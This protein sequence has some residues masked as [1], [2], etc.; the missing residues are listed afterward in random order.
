MHTEANVNSIKELIETD[1]RIT[2]DEIV[3]ETGISH[4]TVHTILHGDLELSKKCARWV[5]CLLT[6]EHKEAQCQMTRNFITE[7]DS[8]KVTFLDKLVTMDETWVNFFTPELKR[9]SM[10]WLPKGVTSQK[11][12]IQNSTHKLMLV[13][14]FDAQGLVY[15]HYLPPQT[16]INS[17]NHCE[18]IIIPFR[19]HLRQKRPEKFKSG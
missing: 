14:F 16:K 3:T 10:Q 13:A 2:I 7:Y 15:Q 5:P 9:Q 11:A 8:N 17:D 12:K 6:P 18:S 1:R 19:Y 4:G